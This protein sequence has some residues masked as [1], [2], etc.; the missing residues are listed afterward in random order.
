MVG[1]RCWMMWTQSLPWAKIAVC[2]LDDVL[3]QRSPIPSFELS[4]GQAGVWFA[5]QLAPESAACSTGAYSELHGEFDAAIFEQAARRVVETAW[6]LCLQIGEG[7]NAPLQHIEPGIAGRWKLALHDLTAAPDP[8]HE[9]W[10]LMRSIMERPFDVAGREPLFRWHLL[11][12]ADQRFIWLQTYHHL[13]VDG[14]SRQILRTMVAEQYTALVAGDVPPQSNIA[15]LQEVLLDPAYAPGSRAWEEDRAYWLR[16]LADRPEPACLTTR[17]ETMRHQAVQSSVMIPAV[18]RDA[19]ECQAKAAGAG[20]PAALTAVA[21]SYVAAMAARGELLIGWSVSARLGGNARRTP[22]MLSNVVP[23]RVTIEPAQTIGGLL[24]HMAQQTCRALRHQRFPALALRRAAGIEAPAPDLFETIVNIVRYERDVS[25]AG[26]ICRTRHLSDGPVRDLEITFRDEGPAGLRLTVFGNIDRTTPDELAAHARRLLHR[27][28]LF[29]ENPA[30]A[31]IAS[32]PMID[33]A[34]RDW[35]LLRSMGPVVAVDPALTLP[36]LFDAWLE[37]QPDAPALVFRDQV[38]SYAELHAQANRLARLLIADGVRPDDVVA[39]LLERSVEHVVAM[40]AVIKAGAAYLPLDCDY[41]TERLRLMLA[42]G[43]PKRLICTSKGLAAHGIAA[44]D[45]VCLDDNEVGDRLGAFEPGPVRDGE[46]LTPL[47]ADNLAYVIYTSGSTGMPKAVATS[48]AAIVN[49]LLWM[50]DLL[51]LSDA[52]RVLQKTAIGFDVSVWEW[53]LPLITGATLVI[54]EPNGHKDPNYLLGM[55]ERHAVTVLHFVPSVL[56]VFLDVVG[57]GGCGSLRHVVASGEA[58]GGPVRERALRLLPGARLWNL[59]GPTEA[60]IDVTSWCCT[61]APETEPTPIGLPIWNTQIYLLDATLEPVPDGVVGDLYIAGANLAH[62]YLGRPDLTA[63]RFIVCP[64][65]PADARMYR[66]GDL[67]RRRADGAMVFLGRVDD[68]VKLH[69]MRIEPGEIEAALISCFGDTIAQAVVLADTGAPPRLIAYL[70]A[71]R[72]ASVP[73]PSR[74]MAGL[75]ETLPDQI[76][77]KAF[78]VVEALPLTPNGKLDRKAL[79][80]ITAQPGGTP[81]RVSQTPQTALLC[82]LYAEITGV[83]QV[84]LDDSF[85]AIGGDSLLAMRLMGRV[86]QQMGKSLP[87]QLLF[88]HPTP[89]GLAAQLD[90]LTLDRRPDLR[91]GMGRLGAASVVLSHGQQRFWAI[92]SVDPLSA[93]YNVPIV[94]RLGGAVDVDALR[95]ALAAVLSRHEALRTLIVERGDGVVEGLLTAPPEWDAWLAITDLSALPEQERAERAEAWLAAE[96]ARPFLIEREVPWRASL[97]VL[98]PDSAILAMTLHHHAA[99]GVSLSLLADDLACAYAAAR[100]GRPPGWP[101]LP[102]QFSDWAAWQQA[103]LATSLADKISR[104]RLRLGEVPAGLLLPLDHPRGSLRSGLAGVLPVRLPADLVARLQLLAQQENTTLFAVVLAAYAATLGRIAGQDKVMIG[105]PT[106]GRSRAETERVIGFFVNTIVHAMSLEAGC[107]GQRLIALARESVEAALIDQDLPFEYLVNHLGSARSLSQTPLFQA[108]LAFQTYPDAEFCLDGLEVS[109]MPSPPTTA[110]FDV[111]LELMPHSSGD[112]AGCLTYDAALFEERSAAGWVEAFT[113]LTAALAASPWQEIATLPLLSAE[114]RSAL[115]A[116]SGPEVGSPHSDQTLP[117]LF[118]AQVAR[119]PAATALAFGDA[120]LGYAALDAQADLLAQH[121]RHHGIGPDDVIALAV[122]RSAAMIVAMLGIV[123]SGAAYMPLDPDYPVARIGFMLEDSGA[124]LILATHA[125]ARQLRR[126]FDDGTLPPLLCIDDDAWHRPLPAMAEAPAIS[127]ESLAYL[128]YTSGSTGTPKAVATTH[129][130]VC[131][132]AWQ[133]SYCAIG[134]DSVVLQLAPAN[135]DAA[136]FEIWGALLNGATLALHPAGEPDLEAIAASIRRYRVNVMWLTAGLFAAAAE[137]LPGMFAGVGQL[138]VGGDVVSPQAV[139]AVLSQHDGLQVVNGYG[140]TETTTFAATWPI[141]PGDTE[142][143]SLPIGRPIQNTQIFLL[144]ANLEPVPDGVIGEIHIAGRGVARGYLG[145]PDLTAER[146]IACPFGAS[147]RRM[148]RSGDLARRRA[149]GAILFIGRAD[150]Q[151]KIRGF[152]VEPG[153]I[154]AALFTSVG[155]RLAHAVVM[156]EGDDLAQRLVAYLVPRQGESLPDDAV[157]RTGLAEIL[158]DYMVPAH[159]EVRDALALTPNGKVD[160]RALARLAGPVSRTR[161]RAPQTALEQLLGRLFAEVTGTDTI[162]L[163]DSFFAVGG[164]SLLALRLISRARAHGIAMSV[165]N[166]L[167][168]QTP[169][170]L[171]LAL[172]PSAGQGQAAGAA[173][174]LGAP[175]FVLPGAGGDVPTMALLRT[176]RE[177]SLNII[178]VDIGDWTDLI[179][180]TFQF[181]QLIARV[182]TLITETAPTGKVRLAGYSLGGQMAWAVATALEQGGRQ[183]EHVM[184][185]DSWSMKQQSTRFSEAM[186]KSGRITWQDELRQLRDAQADGRLPKQLARIVGRRLLGRRGA[187]LLGWLARHRTIMP[188]RLDYYLSIDLSMSLLTTHAAAWCRAFN[189]ATILHAPVTLL[190]AEANAD[191]AWDLGWQQCS[192]QLQVINVAGDHLTM[193][194]G[195]NIENVAAHFVRV[196]SRGE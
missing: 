109:P 55:I 143:P 92:Y 194:S 151:V 108:M 105:S 192:P 119:S 64:F 145:R 97:T 179:A 35:L 41:P 153:E 104:A 196:F 36:A 79:P 95:L 157:L 152:R 9:A 70:V 43:R 44:G 190:R 135:F 137:A 93:S 130:N 148:Y 103:S 66:S 162:G 149:D 101:L 116:G 113:T 50:Q 106:A 161:Y 177:K 13:V 40:L 129:A 100:S 166:I 22:C 29:G 33:A 75:A 17:H 156:A 142:Q 117:A 20:L 176:L 67:A 3:D 158:P 159:F 89:A 170:R 31:C 96:V 165:R 5:Q 171:A 88:S 71:Q 189:E 25:F 132:L 160:R 141:S 124:K 191:R 195:Q 169:G 32:L 138:L 102:V 139:R 4:A 15:A 186:E 187:P 53:V 180:P 12:L 65:G 131:S 90:G 37:S 168:H 83:D 77:P 28:T 123:K 85:F 118:E 98:A 99:D 6:T 175:V 84:G 51:R 127:G 58:L 125:A 21:A 63:E 122:E 112:L 10:R 182:I 178:D 23:L 111:M 150:G 19:L 147:G 72:G 91:A 78:M 107:T 42:D 24:A 110:K 26:T 193:L 49:R 46:R 54:C 115:L 48:H 30:C 7:E 155:D 144:D 181:D 134:P 56:A 69:G 16:Q 62:G 39:V 76:V 133:P 167:Q 184:L 120:T 60:A 126:R 68:Q 82:R 73:E 80:R 173:M 154:E 128:I 174:D 183:V 164:D 87:L 172:A 146:F 8:L 163:D 81:F 45:A 188:V 1:A 52:D 136:T 74:L 14:R 61:T 114:N 94:L 86:R 59:Y 47:V 2:F 34:E 57:A 38:V 185:I 18:A 27:V 121:L 11:K 140:P